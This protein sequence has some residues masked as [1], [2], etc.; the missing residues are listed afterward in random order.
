MT[1]QTDSVDNAA[2]A[3]AVRINVGDVSSALSIL[4]CVS[5]SLRSGLEENPSNIHACNTLEI[6]I[7]RISEARDEL[8]GELSRAPAKPQ[9]PR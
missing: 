1:R 6:A 5:D 2:L 9:Q 4:R 7:L 8:F 3:Q